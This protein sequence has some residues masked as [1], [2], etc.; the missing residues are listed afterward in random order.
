M[1]RPERER[2]IFQRALG[3]NAMQSP[4]RN[5]QFTQGIPFHAEGVAHK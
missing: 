1:D 4:G 5:R 2:K 3:V